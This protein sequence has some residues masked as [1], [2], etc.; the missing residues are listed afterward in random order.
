M[1]QALVLPL[2]ERGDFSPDKVIAVV[3]T[4]LSA[5]GLV[6]RVPKTLKVFSS[7]D[8]AAVEV[9]KPSLQLLAVKPNH[10]DV[11]SNQAKN[12]DFTL[13]KRPV[14]VSLL[15][16][17]SLKRLQKL[18]PNHTCVRAVPNTPALVGAGLTGLSWAGDV[19]SQQRV[20][21]KKFFTALSE[22]IE[23]PESQLD[24][25]LALA[26]SGPAYIALIAE[27]LADGAVAAGLPRKLANHIAHRTIAGTAALLK[28]KELHPGELKDMVASPGGTTIC[29]LRH[30]ESAGVRSAFIE[31]V[32]AAAERSREFA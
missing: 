9:W 2:L 19:D 3:G 4:E 28:E 29:A 17:V 15:A 24:A 26:S 21:I 8:P 14:L 20:S 5:Q 27:A 10:L 6:S 23:L 12:L 25:F 13:V 18:F 22:V 7:N 16:G 1:A 31:A 30:L 32:V 11:V